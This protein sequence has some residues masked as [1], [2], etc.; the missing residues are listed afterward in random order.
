M[1]SMIKLVAIPQKMTATADF[2]VLTQEES[3]GQP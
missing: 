1:D 2:P 3:R